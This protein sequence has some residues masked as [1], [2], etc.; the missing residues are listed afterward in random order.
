M[1]YEMVAGTLP[2]KGL[3][4]SH[5]IVQ[6]L[7]KDPLPLTQLENVQV[8]AEL[9]RIVS[10]SMAKS[11]D[12]RY[13]SAKDML[14]D[15]R[16]LKKEVDRE[17]ETQRSTG[18][19][20]SIAAKTDQTKVAPSTSESSGSDQSSSRA[21]KKKNLAFAVL[22]LVLILAA[23]FGITTWRSS[24]AGGPV[25]SDPPPVPERTLNYWMTVQKFR[26]GKPFEKPFDSAGEINFEKDYQVRL[27][28]SSPDGGYLY[29]LNESP[30]T[31]NSLQI[32]FPSSTANNGSALLAQ[33]KP[34]LIP[35]QS[36]FKLDAEQGPETLWLVF[37]ANSIPELEALKRF[38]NKKDQGM[39]SDNDSDRAAKKF[40]HD[41]SIPKPVPEK[42]DDLKLTS[43]RN[44]ASVFVYPIKLAH[45]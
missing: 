33:H 45:N 8:P 15:L 39:I 2:F 25:R 1:I 27:N 41:N 23:G 10:K 36:W 4:S 21:N 17:A 40:L 6:I 11:A 5:T 26:D 30:V 42:S 44:S 43:I 38:A 18:P 16:N 14:I 13:Q 31:D 20:Q 37:S 7:D 32:L 28:V 12:E 24:R 34:V 3:T 19:D 9:Q 29:V 35:E 22:A